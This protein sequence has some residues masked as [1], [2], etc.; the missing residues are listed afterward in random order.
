MYDLR[1]IAIFF[2]CAASL[3]LGLTKAATADVPPFLVVNGDGW[4]TSNVTYGPGGWAP[5]SVARAAFGLQLSERNDLPFDKGTAGATFWV[6]NAGCGMKFAGFGEPCGWQLGLAITQFRSA[7]I[8]GDGIEIDG[9]SAPVP[10]G[11]IVNASNQGSRLVGLLTNTFVDFSGVDKA[12]APSWFAGFDI[13]RDAFSVSRAASGPHEFSNLLDVDR[14]GNT[15][16][17]G[18]LTTTRALQHAPNQWATRV[19]LAHGTHA[20]DYATPFAQPPVCVATS[21]GTS[22]VRVSPTTTACTVTSDDP[23]DTAIVDIIVVGNPQ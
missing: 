2:I 19:A 23:N 9:L 16:V 4:L 11:R 6:R 1:R 22:R 10:Y 13:A 17:A 7:V 20:F 3:S 21:E 8:G 5:I 15:T 18:T 12:D 14:A